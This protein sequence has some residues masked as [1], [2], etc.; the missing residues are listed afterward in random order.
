[1]DFSDSSLRALQYA[2]SLT[3]EAGGE[4]TV[5][6]VVAHEFEYTPDIEH[7]SGMRIGE[8]LKERQ[9]ALQRRLRELVVGAPESC[10]VA[11][12]MTRGKPW[13]EVLRIAAET[14]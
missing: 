12:L 3:H 2:I 5:L 10:R 13:R 11:S 4:L 14:E 9:D 7:K 8:F 6:P 1:V